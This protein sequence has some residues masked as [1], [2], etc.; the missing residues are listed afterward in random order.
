VGELSAVLEF[1][2]EIQRRVLSQLS[3]PDPTSIRIS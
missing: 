2:A 3:T 1:A